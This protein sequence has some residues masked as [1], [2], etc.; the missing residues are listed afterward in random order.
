MERGCHFE[1][2][3]LVSIAG[4]EKDYDIGKYIAV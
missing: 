4:R 3:K 1:Q 2:T